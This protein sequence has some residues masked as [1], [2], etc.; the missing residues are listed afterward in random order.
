MEKCHWLVSTRKMKFQT[1]AAE[2][3]RETG[4]L[5]EEAEECLFNNLHGGEEFMEYRHIAYLQLYFG[6]FTLHLPRDAVRAR[7]HRA[8]R[9]SEADTT[10]P[11]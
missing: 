7:W 8:R 10:L 11:R 4:R 5:L 1:E 2:S 6:C 9:R 3:T